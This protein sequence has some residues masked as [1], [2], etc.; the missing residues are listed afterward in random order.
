MDAYTFFKMQCLHC[1]WT[2][3]AAKKSAKAARAPKRS[4]KSARR[5]EKRA[6]KKAAKKTDRSRVRPRRAS[7]PAKKTR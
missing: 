1:G 5:R 4:A 3:L 7:A 6:W 2:T